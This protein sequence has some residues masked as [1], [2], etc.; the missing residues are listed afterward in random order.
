V[1]LQ[2]RTDNRS[3]AVIAHRGGAGLRPENTL[4]AL[5]HANSLGVHFSEIDLHMS[6]DGVL[7]VIHDS[8]VDRTTNG[9]GLVQDLTLTQL[10]QLDAGYTWSNDQGKTFPFR[11]QGI[12]I[13]TLTEVFNAFPQQPLQLEIK[14]KQPAILAELRT[15]ICRYNRTHQTLISGFDH[16][17]I[18]TFR[19]LFPD[20]NTTASLR[21]L[22]YFSYFHRILPI[23]Y[24]R[25]SPILSAPMYMLTQSFVKKAHQ[26]NKHVYVWTVNEREDMQRMIELGV[27]AIL[28]DFPDRLLQLL[29]EAPV[30]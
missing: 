26:K 7:V 22:H 21:E 3:I 29:L 8:T 17:T 23:A 1:F 15:L 27:N 9:T 20:V 24:P 11:G 4:S 25:L 30:I 13:P 10:K 14:Q 16:K 2:Y 18:K 28:T 5:Q 6:R 19:R 12:T